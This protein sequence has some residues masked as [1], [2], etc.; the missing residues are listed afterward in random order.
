MAKRIATIDPSERTITV[1]T[2]EEQIKG[3][4]LEIHRSLKAPPSEQQAKRLSYGYL[5]LRT[6][7]QNLNEFQILDFTIA[8]QAKFSELRQQRIR[9]GTQDLRIAA[10]CL[11]NHQTLVTRNRQDF[12]QVPGLQM[13]DWTI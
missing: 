7:V 8:A 2:V 12:E 1:I 9:I 5:G 11:V 3:W 13:E 4:F 10:I 6:A